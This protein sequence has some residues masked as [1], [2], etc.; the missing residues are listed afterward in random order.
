MTLTPSHRLYGLGAVMFVALL[1]STRVP[2]GVGAPLYL[3]TLAVAG[4]AYLLAVREIFVTSRISRAAS[5]SLGWCWP[6][7]GK[8]HF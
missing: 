3:N 4:V 1:A 2:G 6:R 5:S 8:F 7:C